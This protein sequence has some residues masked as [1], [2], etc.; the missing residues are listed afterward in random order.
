MPIER[1][2]VCHPEGGPQKTKLSEQDSTDINLIMDSWLGQ[3]GP[4]GHVNRAQAHYGDFSSGI[5]YTCAMNAVR[6]ADRDFMELPAAV[7]SHV[8]NDPAEFLR[9][10]Y[11]P[12]R[13]AELEELGLVASQKPLA[14]KEPVGA[15]APG[16]GSVEPAVV[17]E[18]T[19]VDG[20]GDGPAVSAPD[21]AGLFD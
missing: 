17:P 7:R 5:D 19:G 14:P 3:G 18:S 20:A 13:R 11:D 10:V 6:D 21:P 12:S 16:S 2:R 1:L 4:V 9:L 8:D 15:A